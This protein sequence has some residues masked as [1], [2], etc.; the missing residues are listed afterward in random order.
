MASTKA[1][2]EDNP[3]KRRG[4]FN[5]GFSGS[6]RS[7]ARSRSLLDLSGELGQAPLRRTRSSSN[8]RRYSFQDNGYSSDRRSRLDDDDIMAPRPA[9]GYSAQPERQRRPSRSQIAS[10]DA[11]YLYDRPNSAAGLPVRGARSSM[12]RSASQPN[13]RNK[14]SNTGTYPQGILKRNG[15]PSE[16]GSKYGSVINGSVSRGRLPSQVKVNLTI[17]FGQ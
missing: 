5:E 13:L 8:L 2:D 17:L 16:D 11:G 10:M 3:G 9:R 7:L 15:A 12:K 6:H 14:I 1:R 4:V